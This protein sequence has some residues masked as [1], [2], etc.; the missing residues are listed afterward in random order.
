MNTT[1]NTNPSTGTGMGFW[2]VLG[3]IAIA[4]I[5]L[6]LVG[7]IIKGLF[8]IG[9]V[10]LAIYGG[11]MLYRGSRNKSGPNPPATF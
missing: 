3:V 7:P 5:V 6:A 10:A 1:T 11:F 2:K 4:L 8:W 9:L